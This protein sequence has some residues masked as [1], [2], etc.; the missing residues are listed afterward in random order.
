MLGQQWLDWAQQI[1]MSPEVLHR[2]I[3]MASE[4]IDTVPQA[5][6]LVTLMAVCG[7]T[8]KESYYDVIILTGLKTAVVFIC[9]AIY[10]LT[11]L[12]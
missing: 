5:G 1:G 9:L 7:L 11:G 3:C 6:A 8:H 10:T 2:I 4:C 12:V